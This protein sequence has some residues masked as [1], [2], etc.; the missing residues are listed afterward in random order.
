MSDKTDRD[1]Y[2]YWMNWIKRSK[3]QQ[4]VESWKKAENM[5]LVNKDKDST[6]KS[7][8][9]SGFRLLYERLKSYLDQTDPTFDVVPTLAYFGD[10][11]VLKETECDKRYLTYVWDEQKL[12]RIQSQKLDSTLIRNCG[13]S[14]LGFDTKKWMP[15]LSFLKSIK[16]FTDPDCD[17]VK[18]NSKAIAYE[19]DISVEEFV[20]K[21]ENVDIDKVLKKAG[22]ILSAE[23]QEKLPAD[24]DKKMFRTIKI[25][26][27]F[28]KGDSAIRKNGDENEVPTVKEV[29]SLID[30]EPKRYLQFTEG[31]DKPLFDGE[32]PYDLDNNEFP[33][34][35]LMF[36]TVS[37]DYYSYTDNDHMTRTD[38]LCDSLL[39]DVEE[40][41][42]YSGKKKFAGSLTANDMTRESVESFLN[43][44]KRTYIPEMLDASGKPKIAQI[45]TGKFEPGLMKIYEMFD[46]IRK[47]S[48][49]LGEL[50]SSAPQEFK[51]VTAIA[52]RVQDA[53]SHQHTNRRLSGPMGYEESIKDDAIKILEIAHQYVPKFSLT[54]ASPENIY[55]IIE[56]IINKQKLKG[57]DESDLA[58]LRELLEIL[59]NLPENKMLPLPWWKTKKLVSN[60]ISL[61]Q[62]GVDAIVG[63]ELAEFWRE[64]QPQLEFKLST[65]VRVK[66]GSTRDT[67]QESKSAAMKQFYLEVM[68]PLYEV[69]NRMDL[70]AKYVKQTGEMA[71]I[72]HI[73]E[74]TPT[75]ADAQTAM[76]KKQEAEMIQ[77][78]AAIGQIQPQGGGQQN[79]NV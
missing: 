67:T 21:Y 53:N 35:E 24:V 41:A 11:Q 20:S 33:I 48:S 76:V 75:Q 79:A 51:D 28:A 22:N 61:I 71:G 18:E 42:Y 46:N 78:E 77:K 2:I 66:K 17:G 8:Y 1:L 27:I 34:S 16:T 12:Q 68:Q 70:A 29:K 6:E 4:P 57:I 55:T 64:G 32:W 58:W 10:Q 56:K 49:A 13:Y 39:K 69:T 26:H 60:G 14:L 7:P 50:L 63:Q 73:D 9:L 3:L 15:K 47:E 62:L 31:Y 65:S 72:D 40:N 59:I 44:P 43:D 74:L 19:E 5:L 37:G 54:N 36:N 38:E 25:Y 30:S 23:E 45:D 52:V